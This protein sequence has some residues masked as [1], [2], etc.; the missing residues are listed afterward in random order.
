MAIWKCKSGSCAVLSRIWILTD[1]RVFCANFLD[2]KMRLCYVLRFFQVCKGGGSPFHTYIHRNHHQ[3]FWVIRCLGLR[4]HRVV[5]IFQ[6]CCFQQ[7][8]KLLISWA[9]I[10]RLPAF[11]SASD[12]WVISK[13][14]DQFLLRRQTG[15]A[16]W[17]SDVFVRTAAADGVF[18]LDSVHLSL[19]FPKYSKICWRLGNCTEDWVVSGS[20][21]KWLTQHPSDV[22][23]PSLTTDCWWP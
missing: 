7:L 15:S 6:S 1:L 10:G 8:F 13:R 9:I 5:W 11:L 16:A 19:H 20:Y 2:E 22:L 23:T 21:R 17:F 3:S 12:G 18:K 14:I 4:E